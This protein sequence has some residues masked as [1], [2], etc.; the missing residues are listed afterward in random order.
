VGRRQ[1]VRERGCEWSR[2]AS[3]IR[4]RWREATAGGE[5]Q[6]AERKV[7]GGPEGSRFNTGAPA[8]DTMERDEEGG[9]CQVGV[10]GTEGGRGGRV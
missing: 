4:C 7:R 10:E 6:R 5:G 1:T 9:K 2:P 3:P 8:E